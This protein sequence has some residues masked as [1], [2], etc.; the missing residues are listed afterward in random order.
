IDFGITYFPVSM[1]GIDHKK[2]AYTD[3]AIFRKKNTFDKIT[4]TD[5]PFVVPTQPLIGA[6]N[7]LQG[8]DGWPESA[9]NRFIKY[10]VAMMESAL[11]LCRQGKAAAYLPTF[12]GYLHNKTVKSTYQLQTISFP[13]E[14]PLQKRAIYIAKR[15]ANPKNTLFEK[16]AEAI[17]YV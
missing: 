16:I 8:L 3:M 11:E 4:F 7:K 13:K 17:R 12:I 1:S 9:S 2:I 15:K 10:R 6:P 5:L 14:M